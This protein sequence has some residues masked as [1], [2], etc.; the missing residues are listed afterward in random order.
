MTN[1]EKYEKYEKL[2]YQLRQLGSAAVAFSGGVDSSFLSKV[3]FDELKDNSIA[4]TIVSPM[5]PKS[6]IKEAETIAALIGIKHIQVIDNAIEEQV[7]ANPVD[8]CYHCKKIEFSTIIDAAL[9]NG[10][11]NVLDGSNIDDLADYRPGLNALNE[12]KIISPLRDAGL[13][14]EEIRQ[15]SKDLG[16]S[17]WNKPAF[18]CL[19]SRIPYGEKITVEILEKIDK[20]EEFLRNLGFRQIRVRAHG[21]IARIEIAPLELEKIFNLKLME[22]I[23]MAI[24]SYGFLY[25]CIE[26]E[27]Y[28][29]GALNRAILNKDVK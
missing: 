5:M 15:L 3:C 22:D 27:G 10:I 17:T 16:L 28:K 29:T 12:L 2:K 11:K 21:D 4:V 24:K 19:A 23:S 14:K 9:K 8:R 6:E 20:S 25:V 1:N 18:A 26:L 13:T 7:A